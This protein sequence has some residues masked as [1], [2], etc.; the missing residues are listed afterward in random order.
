MGKNGNNPTPLAMKEILNPAVCGW[1]ANKGQMICL[2]RCQTEG[3]YRYL[4]TATL[5][6]WELPP[7]LPP[8]RELMAMPAIERLALVYLAAVYERRMAEKP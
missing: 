2:E 5:D 7:Q 3:R 4:E 6:Q 1:C 8:F